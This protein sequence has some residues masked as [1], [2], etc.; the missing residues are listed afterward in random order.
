MIKIDTLPIEILEYVYY[1][2]YK[3]D[4]IGRSDDKVIIF[5]DK[6]I[7]KISD[8]KERLLN[9]KNK[10]DFL[11]GKLPVPKSILFTYYND[12]YYY[13]RTIIN[14]ESLISD[15]F[16]NNPSLLI[17]LLAKAVKLL[18]SLDNVEIPFKSSDSEGSSFIHGDLCLP[19]IYVNSNNE[20]SGFIDLDNC[21]LGDPWYDYA[22]M[23]WSLEYNLKNKE[24]NQMLLNEIGISFEEDKY[25]LYIPKEYR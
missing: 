4:D 23:L 14:G 11:N 3:I 5:E 21:G 13:L 19:N 12:K 9:E 24:Y 2:S 17:S 8:N 25:E 10:I 20:I 6:Y 16:I 22:W 18:R 7:L 1:L 15:R